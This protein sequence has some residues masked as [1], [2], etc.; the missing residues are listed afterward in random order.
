MGG[1]G[2]AW[3][4]L[5]DNLLAFRNGPIGPQGDTDRYAVAHLHLDLG[6][7]RFPGCANSPLYLRLADPGRAVAHITGPCVWLKPGL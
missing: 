1:E 6:G 2:G 4:P 3:W 5:E 7:A